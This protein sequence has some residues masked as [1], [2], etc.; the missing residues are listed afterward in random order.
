MRLE[1]V[2]AEIRPRVPWESIDLGCALARRHIGALWKSWLVT[3]VPLWIL[4]ALLL[5]NHPVWFM[6]VSWWLKPLYD[7]VPL[8]VVSRALFGAVPSVL[9]VLKAWPR[10]LV[11][12]LWFALVVGRFSPARGLSMPVSE[13]EGLRR[14]AY[15]QR[16]NLLE[17]NGGEGA[18]MAT[19]AGLLLE[20]VAAFG[21]VM[22]VFMMVPANVSEQWWRSIG[23][24]FDYSEF[25]EVSMSMLWVLAV[26]RLLSFT[27]MEP[28]YVAAG[29]ALYINSRTLTEGWDIELAFKRL[30][31]RLENMRN[32]A[33]V[34]VMVL[35]A[36]CGSLLASAPT[37]SAR[38]AGAR[39]GLHE[40]SAQKEIKEVLDSEDFTV[41]YRVEDVPVEK[42]SASSSSSG[43]SGGVGMPAAFG[44]LIFIVVLAAVVAGLVYLIYANRHVFTSEGLAA[45]KDRGPKTREVMGMTIT[46]ESLPDDVVSAAR[47]AWRD[48]QHQLALSYLY[49]GSITWLVH[50]ADVPIIESDTEADCLRHVQAMQDERVTPYFSNLTNSWIGMAYGKQKPD[51]HAMEHLC[52]SWPFHGMER[53]AR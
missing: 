7:R 39:T 37:A 45:Q 34:M 47:K 1:D 3:V 36:V 40:G 41:H 11:R 53:R 50:R 42:S 19:L 4:L 33:G 43:G 49:R 13:L 22:L 21:M 52:D 48:G 8:L 27:L 31:S 25:E 51:D 44:N 29:F 46:P 18:T 5:R 15:R 12:R 16:V 20:Q 14:D 2:T 32:G 26:V 30:G 23:D 6:L 24:F 35:L 28:F 38:D 10:L 9:E 17:R